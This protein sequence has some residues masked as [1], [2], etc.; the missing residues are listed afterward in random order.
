MKTLSFV[1]DEGANG[2]L[3]EPVSIKDT[4]IVRLELEKPAPVVTLKEKE[5][6][7]WANYGQSPKDERCYEITI[8]PEGMMTIRMAT[9]VNVLKCYVI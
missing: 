9:P 3:S 6:G 4:A 5:D 7:S 1:F 8:R 2:Y